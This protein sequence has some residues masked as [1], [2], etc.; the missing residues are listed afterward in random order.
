MGIASINNQTD[1]TKMMLKCKLV[2][3]NIGSTFTVIS[4]ITSNASLLTAAQ[5]LHK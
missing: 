2:I 4:P 1:W 5:V 3:R